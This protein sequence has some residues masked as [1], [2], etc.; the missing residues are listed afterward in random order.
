M[1]WIEL[2]RTDQGGTRVRTLVNI[3]LVYRLE[4]T[5]RK[6]SVMVE[7]GVFFVDETYDEV[8]DLMLQAGEDV[9]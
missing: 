4:E 5:A 9:P 7:S 3:K 2:H 6:T 1:A 8:L